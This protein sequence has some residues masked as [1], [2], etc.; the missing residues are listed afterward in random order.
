MTNTEIQKAIKIKNHVIKLC[1]KAGKIILSASGKIGFDEKTSARDVV[2]EYDKKVQD[3]LE[4][5]L[6][7]KY[8]EISFLAEESDDLGNV[9]VSKGEFFI[10]DPIDG[11]SNFVYGFKHSAI[12]VAYVKDGNV[13]AGVVYDPYLKEFFTAVKGNGAYLNGKQIAVNKAN[14]K[15]GLAGY[16]TAVYYDELL[17]QTKNIYCALFD[18][19]NDVRRLSAASLDLCYLASG[20]YCCFFETRLAPWDY[21]AGILIIQEAGGIITDFDG[22]ALSFNKRCSV[23]SGNP[24]AYNELFDIINATK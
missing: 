7:K 17:T 19:A 15:T 20:R 14:L 12:S 4:N 10:I 13:L 11:T 8:P 6:S 21:A 24:V 18:K 5:N 9:D 1:K 2:T 22:N 3:F 23:V 16:G